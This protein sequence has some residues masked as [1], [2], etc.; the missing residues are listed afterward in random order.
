MSNLRK[1]KGSP[2]NLLMINKAF[3]D[4]VELGVIEKISNL[5]QFLHEHPEACFLAHMPIFK[6]DRET[7]KCRNVYLSN[8][9]GVDPNKAVTLNNNQCMLVGPCLNLKILTNFIQLRFGQ[10]L[11]CFDIDKAFLNIALQESDSLKLCL[12]WFNNVEKGDFSIVTFKNVHLPFGLKCSPFLLMICL[13]KILIIEAVNDKPKEDLKKVIWANF[14][15]D[16]GAINGDNPY[17][18]PKN[19][20]YNK[21][22]LIMKR[23]KNKLT[24]AMK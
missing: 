10:Y 19:L 24:V 11:L 4:Q 13:Y 3:R 17:S 14:Y 12:L 15:M 16:N 7:T 23:F 20:M 21:F 5:E 18:I 2:D 6:L 1:L 22:I 9:T 8:V